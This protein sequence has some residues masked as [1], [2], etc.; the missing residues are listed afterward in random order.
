MR[1]LVRETG[2]AGWICCGSGGG[3]GGVR[4]D[5]WQGGTLAVATNQT[6]EEFEKQLGKREPRKEKNGDG[7]GCVSP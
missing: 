7:R 6:E 5:E 3:P 2:N 1:L 4:E